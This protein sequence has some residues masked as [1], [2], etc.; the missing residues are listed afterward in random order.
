MKKKRS[1]PKSPLPPMTDYEIDEVISIL[2]GVK[3]NP[4]Q[5]VE[6]QKSSRKSNDLT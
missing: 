4:R 2:M 1:D 3:P 5:K 6:K